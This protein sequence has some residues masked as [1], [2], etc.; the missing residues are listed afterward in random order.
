MGEGGAARATRTINHG[1]D[2]LLQRNEKAKRSRILS[3]IEED[4]SEK[5]SDFDAA[6]F[7]SRSATKMKLK[8]ST[9]PVLLKS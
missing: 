8:T 4:R 1:K 7:E 2:D 6:H 3:R 5:F 9:N